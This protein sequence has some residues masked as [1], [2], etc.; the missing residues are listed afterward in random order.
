MSEP[1][2]SRLPAYVHVCLA[3]IIL[4]GVLSLAGC[5]SGGIAGVYPVT[6][7]VTY[8]G[9]AVE[10]ATVSFLNESEG[11]PATA[12]TTAE[13]VYELFTLDSS[14]ALPGN[15]RVVVTKTEAG[16]EVAPDD[17]GFDPVT[18]A[19]LS[20]EQSAANAG[21]RPAK[22]KDLI[23]SKYS[24]PTSTPLSVEVKNSN[25]VIDLKLE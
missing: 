22:I 12:I 14:G 19:D 13:G 4:C 8:Q 16:P 2:S 5:G 1:L 25:N 24:S 15:Y 23:P 9:K 21:K 18:G 11:R 20:M 17:L 3:V 6:G 10:G 7:T